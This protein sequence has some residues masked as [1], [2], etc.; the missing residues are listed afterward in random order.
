MPTDASTE[1]SPRPMTSFAKPQSV[2][3]K[4]GFKI[5]LSQAVCHLACSTAVCGVLCAVHIEP[6][7]LLVDI[8]HTQC[9]C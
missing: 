6:F 3:E 9:P 1:R 8:Q 4:I 5:H 2:V 7:F